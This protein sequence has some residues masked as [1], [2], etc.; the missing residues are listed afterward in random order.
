MEKDKKAVI[1]SFLLALVC[2]GILGYIVYFRVYVLKD[3]KETNKSDENQEVVNKTE[4]D[5][6]EN[7]EEI[8][9][10]V[11]NELT[12]EDIMNLYAIL[13]NYPEFR[14]DS[15][16]FDTL[17]ENVKDSAVIKYLNSTCID[18]VRIDQNEFLDSYKSIFNHDKLSEDG[19]CALEDDKYKCEVICDNEFI[20]LINKFETAVR[21]EDFLIIYE[22]AAH[23]EHH[24][25]GNIY[26]KETVDSFENIFTF[27]S[28]D[29]INM[30]EISSKLPT[31]KHI[32]KLDNNNY[33]WFSSELVKQ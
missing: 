3:N 28:F 20:S 14:V 1:I 29:E 7:Q 4:E 12:N 26:V 27:Q 13:A 21:N 32:F 8:K 16:N 33:Y 24:D 19:V 31:Y 17:G 2:V 18:T 10:E 23:L 22:K 25:D 30:D 11:K 9:E 5:N 6:G 15:V